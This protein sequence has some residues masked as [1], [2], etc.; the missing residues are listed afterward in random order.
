MPNTKDMSKHTI[1]ILGGSGFVG[2]HLCAVLAKQGH[3]IRVFTRNPHGCRHLTVLPTVSVEQVDIFDQ[4]ALMEASQGCDV[5]INLVGIL[6]EKGRKGKGFYHAHVDLAKIV[7]NVCKHNAISRL[8]HMSALNADAKN[9]SSFYLRTKGEAENYVHMHASQDLK[10]TSFRP[11]VIFGPYDNF[12]NRF[13]TLL[14]YSPGIMMLPSANA[15]FAP[16]YV[17]DVANVV[18]SSID[19]RE[20]VGARYDLCGPMVYTLKH[21]VSFTSQ[22]CKR[23]RLIIGLGK[24]ISNV[25]A[26]IMQYL[27]GKPYSVDN[28]KSAL[29]PNVCTGPFPKIFN[30]Q[31]KRLEYIVPTYLRIP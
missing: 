15:Q 10:V 13:A 16:I 7:V 31:T 20:A 27:P 9:G 21:L 1:A 23:K 22:A 2:R 6:N 8:L 30:L 24:K 19:M 17:L 25:A 3:R 29:T 14:K 18:A 28:Y 11:S 26:Y 4:G 5:M 12:F